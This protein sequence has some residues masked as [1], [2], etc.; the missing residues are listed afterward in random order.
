M[1][2][3]SPDLRVRRQPLSVRI[4]A[5][6]AAC[7]FLLTGLPRPPSQAAEPPVSAGS[8]PAQLAAVEIPAS[9]G[10]VEK[11]VQGDTSR[12][13]ILIQDAH[14]IPQAQFH[15][16]KLIEH[17]LKTYGVTTV[18]LEGAPFSPLDAQV[19]QSYPDPLA[20]RKSLKSVHD[21]GELAGGTAAA[22]FNAAGRYYGLE[23]WPL[24]EEALNL[25]L[26]ASDSSGKILADLEAKEKSLDAQKKAVYPEAVFEADRLLRDF[27]HDLANLPAL[28]TKLE[29]LK[30]FAGYERLERL[31]QELSRD[32][33][34]REALEAQVKRIAG[35][36]RLFF[37]AQ[38]Q[39]PDL[40]KD[41]AAFQASLQ[42][43]QTSRLAPED[44][45]VEMKK[46]VIQYKIP[47]KVSKAFARQ[48]REQHRLRQIEGTQLF[49]ELKTYEQDLFAELLESPEAQELARETLRLR[50]MQRL[51]K[52]ELTHQDWLQVQNDKEI[53]QEDFAEHFAF[54]RNAYAR[55]LV[56]LDHVTQL[57]GKDKAGREPAAVIAVAGGFHSSGLLELLEKKGISTVLLMPSIQD[58]PE[59]TAYLDHMHGEVSWKDY[60]EVEKDG[61]V[62]MHKAFV[63]GIRER[64]L[65]ALGRG[66]GS[67]E[68][69]ARVL[70]T[71]R[72]QI[73]RDL[74]AQDRIL[75]A[76]NYT[77]FM[78]E[79]LEANAGMVRETKPSLIESART[80]AEKVLRLKDRGELNS[81]NVVQ[82]L[83]PSATIAYAA[84]PGGQLANRAEV[85]IPQNLAF[86]QPAPVIS[87]SESRNDKQEFRAKADEFKAA[88][89]D[90]ARDFTVGRELLGYLDAILAEDAI[91]DDLDFEYGYLGD[92]M[93]RLRNEMDEKEIPGQEQNLRRF[94]TLL[95]AVRASLSPTAETPPGAATAS[96][97]LPASNR[98]P[99]FRAQI[100]DFRTNNPWFNAGNYT[101][102]GQIYG[103]LDSIL[104][105]NAAP[106]DPEEAQAQL[107]VF[108][109][110]V[111]DLGLFNPLTPENARS[112]N[113][114]IAILQEIQE[115]FKPTADRGAPANPTPPAPAILGAPTASVPSSSAESSDSSLSAL[116]LGDRIREL[117]AQLNIAGGL[118]QR[119]K[120]PAF[121][122]SDVEDRYNFVKEAQESQARLANADP[123]VIAAV[124]DYEN[125][126]KALDDAIQ[127]KYTPVLQYIDV[128]EEIRPI[129]PIQP[130]DEALDFRNAFSFLAVSRGKLLNSRNIITALEAQIGPGNLP[131]DLKSK[132]QTALQTFENRL[133][134]FET[135]IIPAEVREIE[136]SFQRLNRY[137]ELADALLKNP[138][139]SQLSLSLAELN[140]AVREDIAKN[141]PQGTPE[142]PR[143][144]LQNEAVSE[145]VYNLTALREILNS[146]YTRLKEVSPARSIKMI[147]E[148]SNLRKTTSTKTSGLKDQFLTYGIF[149]ELNQEAAQVPA[150][151]FAAAQTALKRAKIS[152]ADALE[153]LENR[154]IVLGKQS[155]HLS[156]T[157]ASTPVLDV[158]KKYRLI[159]LAL[160][161]E[162]YEIPVPEEAPSFLSQLQQAALEDEDEDTPLPSVV[163]TRAQLATLAAFKNFLENNPGTNR[164][165]N[166]AAAPAKAASLYTQIYSEG[167]VELAPALADEITASETNLGPFLEDFIGA[168]EQQEMDY[169]SRSDAFFQDL[170]GF[171]AA[172]GSTYAFKAEMVIRPEEGAETFH[173]FALREVKAGLGRVL[174]HGRVNPAL[175]EALKDTA[176]SPV[177]QL[178]RLRSQVSDQSFFPYI[179]D[180]LDLKA[181]TDSLLFIGLD[182]GGY[183]PQTDAAAFQDMKNAVLLQY[184]LGMAA[185][186]TLNREEIDLFNA[187]SAR[188]RAGELLNEREAGRFDEIRGKV[189]QALAAFD[190]GI[191]DI[192][193]AGR[194]SFQIGLDAL[195]R[196]VSQYRSEQKARTSA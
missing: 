31:Q 91:I 174:V 97:V 130:G 156:S 104:A 184:V 21:R 190:T 45:A 126:K 138:G 148:I 8:L 32:A 13:V 178:G 187:Y 89:P 7:A 163:L 82:L 34:S 49:E 176:Y 166:R 149:E 80:F 72:D 44:F 98:N 122:A 11:I 137:A 103:Y 194:N 141:L 59:E 47:V 120:S 155:G 51:A 56:F 128:T 23:K 115:S 46:W 171:F 134:E 62:D 43:F 77:H 170:A 64:L 61:S 140:D 84:S 165:E 192:V 121:D 18:A 139:K 63:R 70:K 118:T 153:V 81:Q 111:Q 26:L 85:R 180:S 53:P 39:T 37:A 189:V 185:V 135:A 162:G 125:V 142:I 86:G 27:H 67:A 29:A 161:K 102:A 181:V 168:I 152:P 6:F 132:A 193:T 112:L 116:E 188:L 133:N 69:R 48:V 117:N 124:F 33:L 182:R 164:S 1:M 22:I 177:T 160:N 4:T 195:S 52:L 9:I 58:L 40:K 107:A 30:S 93:D 87:R 42:A 131:S 41:S 94:F 159:A 60:I 106:V 55:D 54:Y 78:D 14:S 74:A 150:E 99:E 38:A 20:L 191:A 35:K 28:F 175:Q 113:I 129:K 169:A 183:Q 108:I 158:K 186:N 101:I 10:S 83:K 105:E 25:Y 119:L 12:T 76:K 96:A 95:V 2:K 19:F 151:G 3:L 65:N 136:F 179:S 88:Y 127:E 79:A 75:D 16:Q 73:L 71:W 92:L 114:F 100:Q 196:F 66:D 154:I 145:A 15:I 157:L 147:T 167:K 68:K 123:R 5:G 17:F 172:Q 146:F 110:T 50:L 144:P 143:L 90:F 109:D 36:V 57:L 24:Y 173:G